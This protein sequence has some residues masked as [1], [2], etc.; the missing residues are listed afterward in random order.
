YITYM[1]LL[2]DR[3]AGDLAVKEKVVRH[4]LDDLGRVSD[5]LLLELFTKELC[6]SFALSEGTVAA[7]LEQRKKTPRA[8]AS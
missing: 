5:P 4:I 1:K 8:A 6:R 2:V 7:A 3:R